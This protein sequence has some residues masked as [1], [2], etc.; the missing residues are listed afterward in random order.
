MFLNQILMI[1]NETIS[2]I[3]NMAAF[4]E[5]RRKLLLGKE[6]LL[7]SVFSLEVHVEKC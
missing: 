2:Q 6:K 5:S 1:Q 7:L 3:R 4:S